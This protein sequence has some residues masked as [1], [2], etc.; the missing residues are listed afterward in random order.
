[1]LASESDEQKTIVAYFRVRYPKYARS[2]RVSQSGLYRGHGREGA[3]R[4]AQA[5]KLGVVTGESD[6]AFLIP[7]GGFGCLL[8]E[9]KPGKGGAA[10]REQLDYLAY[11]NEAGNLAVLTRGVEAA[12]RAID[13]YMAL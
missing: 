8:L 4:M 10:T 3:K 7:R 1:M 2:I 11:H 9:H 12:I 6:L 13:D 5:K